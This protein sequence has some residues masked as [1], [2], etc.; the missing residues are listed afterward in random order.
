MNNNANTDRK[1]NVLATTEEEIAA[2][3]GVAAGE[4][5]VIADGELVIVITADGKVIWKAN[6]KHL[7][8][9]QLAK[10][11]AYLMKTGFIKVVQ[12]D[13]YKSQSS[14]MDPPSAL[15]NNLPPHLKGSGKGPN[16]FGR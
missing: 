7:D 2:I 16:S 4:A 8:A 10:I 3:F 6:G 1:E 5:L 15:R 11:M 14:S 13:Q 12:K 9:V